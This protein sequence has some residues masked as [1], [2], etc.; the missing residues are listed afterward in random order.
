MQIN[1]KLLLSLSMQTSTENFKIVLNIISN[2]F[3]FGLEYLQSP[4]P[5]IV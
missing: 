5:V 2:K 1:N 4:I 3:I